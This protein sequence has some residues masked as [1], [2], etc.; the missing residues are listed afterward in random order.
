[1]KTHL[2]ARAAQAGALLAVV[3]GGIAVTP[4]MAFAIPPVVQI[5]SLSNQ[6]LSGSTQ[7][8]QFRVAAFGNGNG[9]PG[10]GNGKIAATIR[11]SGGMN[12]SGNS[13]DQTTEVD[14]DGESFSVQLKAPDV[15]PGDTRQVQVTVTAAVDGEQPGSRTATVTVKGPDKPQTVRQITGTV[16]DQD[17][18]A[19]SNAA[20]GIQDSA[21][22]RYQ[23]ETNSSGKYS[24]T[25]SDSKPIAPGNI[26]VGAGKDGY[27]PAS[28]QVQG[29]AGRTVNVPLTLKE[30]VS[31]A[32]ASP[33]ASASATTDPTDEVTEDTPTEDA[34]T[35]A[36]TDTEK[37]A[38][39]D[40][41][42][43]SSWIYIL[44]GGLLVAAGIGAMVLVFLRRKNSNGGGDDDD[45][46]AM[47]GPGGVVPPSQGRFN[48]ATRVAAPVG[49]ASS[50]TMVAPR[51][52]A[53]SMS[54]APTMLQRPVP[55]VEDEF[56]D[57]YGAPMPAHGGYAGTP[58]G[59]WDDQAGGY[60][61][62]TPY[63]GG[64]ADD[65]YGGGQYGA[66]AGQYGGGGT[67]PQQRY[68]EPTGMYQ[69]ADDAGYDDY[70]RGGA[71]S[72]G[73]YGGGQYG[74]TYGGGGSA[75]P[76]GGNY[77]GGQ[78]GQYGGGYGDQGGYDQGYDQGGGYGPQSGGTYGGSAAPAGGNYGGGQGGQ[79]GGGAGY[80][81]Q[82]GYD[83]RGGQYGDPNGGGYR[84][85]DDQAGY[86]QRGGYG[87][88]SRPSQRRPSDWDN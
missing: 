17:G 45:P 80:G 58:A 57:P 12:C 78:G 67:Q 51:S 77:G 1:M 41:S 7:T 42:G 70:G 8:M 75:A 82:G 19:I 9:N 56:P 43:G 16:K 25:S 4:A 28:V 44:I 64:A 60:D 20:V 83:Q 53:P 73:N 24:I 48:D 13:C 81:D 50:A 38:S 32:S 86:D 79:Y 14:Q 87:G 54:D 66:G 62:Q 61:Q 18:K 72:G 23:T 71:A 39:S 46:T 31:T 76:A 5:T 22:A 27:E 33:S 63:G 85:P 6:V 74:G 65:G 34:T 2:R 3:L 59:G 40:D 35:P 55:P 68:D 52:G 36:E 69:P 88:Q 49:G 11:V 30:I 47:G 26:S 15:R 21:G 29:N 84:E 37:T 10:Q